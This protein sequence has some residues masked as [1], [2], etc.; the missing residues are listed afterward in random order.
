MQGFLQGKKG[1]IV[2]VAND[3][4]IASG[5]AM[6]AK[7]QGAR[8]ALTYLS[9]K[10]KPHVDP[11]AEACE[12]EL[13]MPLDVTDDAQMDAVFDRIKAEWGELDFLI[14][15]IA[16]CP[17]QDL[18][19]RVTDCSR[20]GFTQA[21]D[22]SV[23]SFTRM[24]RRAEPLMRN[25]GSLLT[26][27]YYGAEKV[28]DHYNV[29]GPVKAALESVSRYMAAE[30]GPKGIRVNAISPGPLMTRAAS[31]IEKF[32]ALVDEAQTRAPLRRLVTIQEVGQVAAC[33]LSPQ[34]SAIT[35]NVSYVDGGYHIMS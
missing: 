30:L 25:G 9:D 33:L 19:G 10:A 20:D 6:V 32:D 15:S 14:H 27:S 21:M 17:K 34:G 35:G 23:H 24:A 31:G 11:V 2:G 22:I 4:S 5:C 8:L 7:E 12:A 26:V 18:H 1:L 3:Q 29:M 16:F 13:L 28:V